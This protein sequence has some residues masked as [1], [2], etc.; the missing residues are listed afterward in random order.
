MWGGQVDHKLVSSKG[1]ALDTATTRA[2]CDIQ[3]I[4]RRSSDN[5]RTVATKTC[6]RVE[7]LGVEPFGGVDVVGLSVE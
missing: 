2:T 7:D 4:L 6:L 5:A 3:A 1:T